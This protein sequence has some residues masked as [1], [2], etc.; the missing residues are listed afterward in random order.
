M[1]SHESTE[2]LLIKK[3][4]GVEDLVYCV[5]IPYFSYD[6]YSGISMREALDYFVK[7][8]NSSKENKSTFKLCA[9]LIG[10]ESLSVGSNFEEYEKYS[11]HFITYAGDQQ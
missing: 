3:D 1:I 7:Q 2:V 11:V 10:N 6:G 9:T 4:N 5:V 8:F